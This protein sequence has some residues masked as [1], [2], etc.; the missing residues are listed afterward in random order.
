MFPKVILPV[1]SMF[2]VM[3]PVLPE[4]VVYFKLERLI[5]PNEHDTSVFDCWLTCSVDCLVK[6]VNQVESIPA[7][8]T[9]N[10]INNTVAIKG[11][12]PLFSIGLSPSQLVHLDSK[13]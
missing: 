10:A 8:P 6:P 4:I 13:L 2:P 12:I 9:V 3:F 1:F 7:T 5:P 11:D